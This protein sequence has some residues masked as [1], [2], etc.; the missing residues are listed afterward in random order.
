MTSSL[1]LAAC[2]AVVGLA[3]VGI[4]WLWPALFQADGLNPA[5]TPAWLHLYFGEVERGRELRTRLK[6]VGRRLDAQ[7]RICDE[8]IAGR[9][10]LTEAARRVGDLPDPPDHFQELLRTHFAGATD[11]ERL[12]HCVLQWA[13]E[14]LVDQPERA[15]ALRRRW[16][17]ELAASR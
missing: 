6:A 1:R 16:E 8:L 3:L 4:C 11:E 15:Q 14:V 17:A 7:A 2:A 5:E 12:A 13:C 9:I 10:S